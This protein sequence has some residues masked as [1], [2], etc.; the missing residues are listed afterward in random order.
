MQ[1]GSGPIRRCGVSKM[2]LQ[3]FKP[4]D[5]L[6]EPLLKVWSDEARAASAEARAAKGSEGAGKIKDP[7]IARVAAV[8]EKSPTMQKLDAALK[9]QDALPG[10]VHRVEMGRNDHAV[11]EVLKPV[12]VE[13]RMRP[14]KTEGVYL[15]TS[16][17]PVDYGEVG[18]LL[19]EKYGPEK[20]EKSYEGLMN[21][22]PGSNHSLYFAVGNKIQMEKVS[23]M[24]ELGKS[25]DPE[26]HH[27][28]GLYKLYAD[29]M[30][31]R[32]K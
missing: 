26:N 32:K 17:T 25:G 10:G 20:G 7:E 3:V 28:Q 8:L 18:E 9:A 29:K 2:K 12:E 11:T 5:L 15:D 21:K 14:P 27:Y 31:W 19:R 23:M 6:E 13:G 22:D 4:A 16:N 24:R 1:P 30:G